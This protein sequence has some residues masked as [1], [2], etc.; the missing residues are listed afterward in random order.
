ML[1]LTLRMYLP[2]WT[3]RLFLAC[4]VFSLSEAASALCLTLDA[5]HYAVYLFLS[6]YLK[7]VPQILQHLP[8]CHSC[9]IGSPKRFLKLNCKVELILRH[10]KRIRIGFQQ[11]HFLRRVFFHQHPLQ[12]YRK[13]DR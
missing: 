11:L 2:V 3:V 10:F 8:R 12:F 4:P 7:V 5:L 1:L 6:K 9:L 13:C